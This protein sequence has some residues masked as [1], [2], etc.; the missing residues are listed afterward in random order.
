MRN[1][2]LILLAAAL[3]VPAMAEITIEVVENGDPCKVDI[4]YSCTDGDAAG[5]FDD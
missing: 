2:M 1:L 4:T 5:G 3:A